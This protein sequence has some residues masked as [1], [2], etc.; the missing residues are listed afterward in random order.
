MKT[1]LEA[2]AETE[3]AIETVLGLLDQFGPLSTRRL[4]EKKND[5]QPDIPAGAMYR[6]VA[7][8]LGRGRI[9]LN[10]DRQVLL[11]K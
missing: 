6:A 3:G 9:A 4:F 11:V 8:L 1:L 2:R 7:H 10:S 5:S